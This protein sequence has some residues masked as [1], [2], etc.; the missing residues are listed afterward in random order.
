MGFNA[1]S[2]L[3]PRRP[4]KPKQPKG[5]SGKGGGHTVGMAIAIFG[6]AGAVAL[7][8]VAFLVHGYLAG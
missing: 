3:P 6:S 2:H 1:E 8:V 4:K 7:G 5:S